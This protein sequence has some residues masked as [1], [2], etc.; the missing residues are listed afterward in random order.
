MFDLALELDVH[1]LIK[2]TF[3]FD[4]SIMMCPQ[5]LPRELF[6]DVIDD[7]LNYIRP[8]VEAN[9]KYNYW[10]TCLE[11]LK[12]RQVFSEQYPDWEEGLKLG[13]ERLAKVDKWRNNENILNE[14]YRNN[15]TGVFNWW[16]K[17]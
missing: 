3:A 12:A 17:S 11:D 7:I 15:H 1:T 5:V 6:D 16:T 2:T 8:K 9:P 4:S 14:I 10:I 13:K